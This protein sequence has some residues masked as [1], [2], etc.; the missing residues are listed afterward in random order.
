MSI[1]YKQFDKDGEVRSISPELLERCREFRKNP[2]S[3]EKKLWQHLRNRKPGMVNFVP[4]QL[5]GFA[6]G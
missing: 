2:T 3:V 1:S 6:S 5:S 4:T